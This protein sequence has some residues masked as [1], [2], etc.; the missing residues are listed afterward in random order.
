MN[1]HQKAFISAILSFAR[2]CSTTAT[3]HKYGDN[4][5][6]VSTGENNPTVSD[7][8]CKV[9]LQ[10]LTRNSNGLSSVHGKEILAGDKDC[11]LIP[12]NLFDSNQ[13]ALDIN[14]TIDKLTVAGINYK[15]EN[16]KVAD[17]TGDSA[18]LYQILLRR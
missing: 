8:S 6:D 7:I 3:L 15:I 12:P 4:V 18:I 16:I 9:I 2:E 17:Q 1:I 10:D 13:P 11:F 14:P 5:Y